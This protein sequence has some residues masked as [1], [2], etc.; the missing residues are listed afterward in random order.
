[1]LNLARTIAICFVVL[2]FAAG[3]GGSGDGDGDGSSDGA[4][5]IGTWSM[6]TE[7][8]K[9]PSALGYDSL[10]VTF[11]NWYYTADISAP[12]FWCY[13]GGDITY[14]DTAITVILED[15]LGSSDFCSQS[16]GS[17]IIAAWDIS[18][19]GD[20]LTLDWRGGAPNGTLQVYTR[21]HDEPQVSPN[22]PI[23]NQDS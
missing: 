5:F 1:M 18:D 22:K 7:D 9:S 20:T 13:W 23:N 2:S 10:L 3:C 12:T 6:V 14:T 11:S 21:E 16:P 19:D 8:G 17:T 15:A 4:A